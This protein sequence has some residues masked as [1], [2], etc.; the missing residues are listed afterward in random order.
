M[1]TRDIL[2]LIES[3]QKVTTPSKGKEIGRGEGYA[4]IYCTCEN[5]F[6]MEHPTREG[7][8]SQQEIIFTDSTVSS[9]H[10]RNKSLEEATNKSPKTGG[11]GRKLDASY[12]TRKFGFHFVFA[13]SN[14]KI[15]CCAKFGA[16]IQIIQDHSQFLDVKLV[17]GDFNVILHPNENQGGDMQRIGPMDDFND[18]MLDTGLIDAGFERDSFNWT[19]KR[20]WRRLDRV[21][22]SKEWAKIL[23][24]PE[25]YIFQDFQITTPSAS[26]HPKS[27]TKSFVIEIPKHVAAPSLFPPNSQAILGAS[28]SGIWHDKQDATDPE[29][30]FDRDPS[31]ANLI[32]L[33]KSNAVLVHALSLEV[34]YWK[35]NSN[36]KWLEA[37]ERNTKYFHSLVKKKKAKVHNP[38]NHRRKSRNTNLDQIRDSATSYFE[39]LL[40]SNAA[41]SGTPDFPFQ[42]SKISEEVGHNICSIPSKEDIKDTVFSIDKDSIAGADGFSLAFYQACWDFIAR[43]IYDAVRDFFSGTLMPRSFKATTIVLIRKVDSAQTWK[44]FRSISLCNVTNKILSKLLYRKL[45][46]A[47]PD[48]ISPSQSDFVLG[49]LI[50]NNILMAQ[51]IIHHLDLRYKNNNFIIK[52][53]MSKAYE[54]VNWFLISVMQK[55]G[56]PP[57]FLTLTKHAI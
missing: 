24:S 46:Q 17:E 42:F 10:K 20:V 37:G 23:T 5:T 33:N 28:Y 32:A 48:L 52:L 34:E 19:N 21:L 55:M 3:T 44:D 14:N 27:R 39:N 4:R 6:P 2:Q 16:D 1:E 30:K 38:Q 26:K 25:C 57:R 29:N 13:N 43:D 9:K 11:K 7:E 56:F 36:C 54:K 12:Y 45:S 31:E 18:M 8:V 51:E 53:D 40:S 22:Y 50:N 15:W 47:L 35:Q 41:Q 49:R